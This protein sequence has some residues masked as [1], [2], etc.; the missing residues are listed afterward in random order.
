METSDQL[1]SQFLTTNQSEECPQADH[2]S[3][4]F[5]GCIWGFN[6]LAYGILIPLPE[7]EPIPLALK[8]WSFNHWMA[9]EVPDH[10]F[11]EPLLQN[12]LL[13][14]PGEDT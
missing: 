10:A 12:S 2:A 5:F 3:F 9:K 6:P 1:D 4:F 7:I 11:F 8:V 14:P 13:S